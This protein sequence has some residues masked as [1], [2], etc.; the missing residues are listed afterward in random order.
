MDLDAM[1]CDAHC[2]Q[3]GVVGHFKRE[4]LELRKSGTQ[5]RR[6]SIRAMLLDLLAEEVIE[7]KD[8]LV[9]MDS[10]VAPQD[11]PLEDINNSDFL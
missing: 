9:S 8:L 1:R 5:P 10:E 7:L 3:C 4:C 6:F 11:G 2:Y